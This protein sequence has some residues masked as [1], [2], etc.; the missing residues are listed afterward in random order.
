MGCGT[1]AGGK[2]HQADDRFSTVGFLRLI[3]FFILSFSQK[4][5]MYFFCF[6]FMNYKVYPL[7]FN[8]ATVNFTPDDGYRS[9]FSD[10]DLEG[11]LA[12]Q[13]LCPNLWMFDV[14]FA[15]KEFC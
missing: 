3:F 2:F 11:F 14:S 8:P 5:Y 13:R 12:F 9:D 6:F 15:V 1:L 10:K 7:T 4:K